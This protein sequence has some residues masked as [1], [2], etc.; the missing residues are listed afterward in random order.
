[1]WP[2]EPVAVTKQTALLGTKA[3]S[4]AQGFCI[5]LFVRSKIHPQRLTEGLAQAIPSVGIG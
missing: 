5:Y 4:N 1:M 2:W 3:L